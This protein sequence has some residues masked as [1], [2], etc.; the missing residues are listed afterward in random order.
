VILHLRF[1]TKLHHAL[2]PLRALI[3]VK[4]GVKDQNTRVGNCDQNALAWQL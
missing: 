2:A 3:N 4:S 1:E